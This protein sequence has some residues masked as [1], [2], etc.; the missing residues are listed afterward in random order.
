MI[1]TS[2]TF[3]NLPSYSTI[4]LIHLLSA[5]CAACACDDHSDGCSSYVTMILCLSDNQIL[6][7]ELGCVGYDDRASA[8]VSYTKFQMLL[9]VES[10]SL[11][12]SVA[13]AEARAATR[14]YDHQNC[15]CIRH[16]IGDNDDIMRQERVVLDTFSLKPQLAALAKI[17]HLFS[18]ESSFLACLRRGCGGSFINDVFSW[19]SIHVL[20]TLGRYIFVLKYQNNDLSLEVLLFSYSYR[21]RPAGFRSAATRPL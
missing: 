17:D 21:G 6:L 15:R 2:I 20:M 5:S 11:V 7:R 13:E 10:S 12:S 4:S 9:F 16:N 3:T 19:D 18:V 14:Y 8:N 1:V